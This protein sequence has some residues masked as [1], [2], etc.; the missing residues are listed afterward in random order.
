MGMFMEAEIQVAER[1]TVAVPVTAVGSGDGQTTVMRVVDG[2][3]SRVPVTLGIRDG[4]MVEI[5][6]GISAGDLVVTKAA[7]FVRDGD[8]INPVP[9]AAGTN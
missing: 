6:E 3:V 9:A 1:E 5:V 4:G 7:A 8:R 2:V